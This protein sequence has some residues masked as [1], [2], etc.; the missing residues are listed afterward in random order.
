MGYQNLNEL[1]YDTLI[2]VYHH[3]DELD[4][5]AGQTKE[6]IG[7]QATLDNPLNNIIIGYPDRK[8]SLSYACAELLWYLSFTGCIDLI[9]HYAPSYK[10][11]AEKGIA[12]GAY[13][14][15][16]R[17][18]PGFVRED[19]CFFHPNGGNQIEVLI[20]L[21][22]EK[23]NT[24]QA[25]LSMWD[26]GDLVHALLG[27]HK[28]LPCTLTLKFFVRDGYL[29]CIADM[30][31]ND[32]WLG[33]PYDIF[34]FTTL[35]RIIAEECELKLGK[36]IHQA[37]SEHLYEC[38]YEKVEKVLANYE[39]DYRSS[40]PQNKFQQPKCILPTK[41]EN[42]LIFEEEHRKSTHDR[43][44]H[45]FF[46]E[47]DSVFQDLVLGCATKTH[48]IS[49]DS[50]NNTLYQEWQIKNICRKRGEGKWQ[51]E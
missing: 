40:S 2:N 46:L 44:R 1:W 45:G 34:C 5:R 38:N 6:I 3:G 51:V 14:A 48:D 28:D 18:N 43:K 9:E 19:T 36:Y 26:S 13:G 7:F 15:R 47:Q 50:F 16:W 29:H 37:G 8:F 25:I 21:L 23:P 24:R 32:A 10:N 35:Q 42:A 27:D 22:K 41:I 31:S 4:S 20:Q 49:P 30:R 11:Y 17:S 39:A 33:L 12:Y